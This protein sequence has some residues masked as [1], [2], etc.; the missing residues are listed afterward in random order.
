MHPSRVSQDL[1]LRCY[2]LFGERVNLHRLS[3]SG[4]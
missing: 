2:I 4:M 1:T 3:Y